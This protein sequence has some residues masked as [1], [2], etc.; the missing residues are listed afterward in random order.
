MSGFDHVLTKPIDP[1]TLLGLIARHTSQ[2][3]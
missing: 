3:A 2:V 1:A